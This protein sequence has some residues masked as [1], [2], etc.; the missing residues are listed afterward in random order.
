MR[1]EIISIGTELLVSDILDTNAAHLSRCLR[2]ANATLTCKVI[3]GDELEM[4]SDALRTGL[5]RADV[6]ITNGGLGSGRSDLTRAAVLQVTGR[7]SIPDPPGISGATLLGEA[8]T[9]RSGL[10]V[11]CEEGFI[12]CLPGDRAEMAYLLETEVLPF[13]HQ[14][15]AQTMHAGWLLLRTTGVMEST[16]K[17]ELAGERRPGY[18]PAIST[19]KDG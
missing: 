13:L 11:K 9:Y 10:V 6:V 18:T 8:G 5:R 19:T 7:A 2:E 1:V 12:V 15:I 14:H 3:V 17:E 4:I 16:L